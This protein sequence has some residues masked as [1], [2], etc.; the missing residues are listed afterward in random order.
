MV[1]NTDQTDKIIRHNFAYLLS[2]TIY[3][4]I[5]LLTGCMCPCSMQNQR[6]YNSS[7][8]LYQ[9][10]Q[11][12]RKILKVEKNSTNAYLRKKISVPDSRPSSVG[13]GNICGYGVITV[14]VTLLVISD[15]PILYRQ[16]RFGTN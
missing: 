13:I 9:R 8:E 16:L 12:L 11:E 7:E 14:L 2:L 4:V 15:A 5:L 10:I 3:C 6:F 1:D